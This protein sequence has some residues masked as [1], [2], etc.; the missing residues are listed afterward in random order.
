VNDGSVVW[1]SVSSAG[2]KVG[3]SLKSVKQWFDPNVI[4]FQN[5]LHA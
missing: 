5:G 3:D 1:T 2:F 4:L